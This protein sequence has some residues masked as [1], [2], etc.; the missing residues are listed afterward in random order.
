MRKDWKANNNWSAWTNGSAGGARHG[1]QKSL[2][3]AIKTVRTRK[4]SISENAHEIAESLKAPV[5]Y[6]LIVCISKHFATK[7][8]C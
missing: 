2:S 7:L 8:F 3:E 5:S 6:K 1:R 4:M